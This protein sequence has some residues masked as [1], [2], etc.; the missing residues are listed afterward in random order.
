MVA[1]HANETPRKMPDPVDRRLR[2][3]I[4]AGNAIVWIAI[5]TALVVMF[6]L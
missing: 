5:I 3:L 4:L 6:S 2:N 1:E